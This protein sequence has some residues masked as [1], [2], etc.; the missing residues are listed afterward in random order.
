MKHYKLIHAMP[1]FVSISEYLYFFQNISLER[2]RMFGE[3]L[4]TNTHL[5]KFH[6]A[7]T[8]ATDK[9]AKVRCKEGLF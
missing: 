8:R 3:A 5:Q 7:N 2:L 6:M 9:V 4:R 1:S